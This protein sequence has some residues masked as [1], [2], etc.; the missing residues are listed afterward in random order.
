MEID[1][2]INGRPMNFGVLLL[3]GE[4]IYIP[5]NYSSTIESV[6]NACTK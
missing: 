6:T 5:I 4:M 2:L 1:H 3:T